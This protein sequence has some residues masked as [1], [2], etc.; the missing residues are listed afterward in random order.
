M[1][2]AKLLFNGLGATGKVGETLLDAARAARIAIPH[3]CGNGTCESCRMIVESGAVDANGSACEASVLACTARV[4]GDAALRYDLRPRE[5]K[6]GGIVRALRDLSPDITEVI[7][8]IDRQIPYLPGQ[9]L[10]LSFAGLPERSYAPTLSLEG[11]RELDTLYFH[12]RRRPDG[13]VS[14]QLGRK[15]TPGSKVKLRGPFGD[16]FLRQADARLVLVSSAEGFAALW[17]VALAAR[18]GQPHRAIAM[19]VSAHDPRNLY[20][21]SALDWLTKHDVNDL[22]TTVSGSLPIPPARSGRATAWLPGFRAGDHVHCAGNPAMIT[23]IQRAATA[24]GAR[25]FATPFAA[26]TA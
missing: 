25:V 24:A 21:R 20:M 26:E 2:G 22:I 9:Y 19:V 18:L 23:A 8:E 17:S 6:A 10:R 3:E 4:T 5:M 1:A 13:V 11:L 14:S 7:I 12:I 16:G 15:I